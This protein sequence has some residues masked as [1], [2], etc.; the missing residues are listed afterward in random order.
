[1]S[2]IDLFP[3]TTERRE[4]GAGNKKKTEGGEIK[5]HT[6]RQREIEKGEV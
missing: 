1:M 4:T 6:G 5:R 2:A 3:V